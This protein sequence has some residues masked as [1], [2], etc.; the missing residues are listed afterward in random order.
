LTPRRWV[1][2]FV[3][4]NELAQLRADGVPGFVALRPEPMTPEAWTSAV[5]AHHAEMMILA[6]NATASIRAPLDASATVDNTTTE[7]E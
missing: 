4:A 3:T 6:R 7:P 5:A 1:S 2:G